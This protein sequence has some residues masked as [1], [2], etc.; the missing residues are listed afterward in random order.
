M[1]LHVIIT[2]TFTCQYYNDI[3]VF[4]DIGA[5]KAL[6]KNIIIVLFIYFLQ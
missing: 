5:F 3:I 6:V 4:E 1:S 2:T